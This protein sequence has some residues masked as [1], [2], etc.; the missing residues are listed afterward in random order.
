VTIELPKFKPIGIIH[1]PY[2]TR[3]DAPHQG[4]TKDE[5]SEIEV[6][7]EY[8]N[9]LTGIERFNKLFIIYCLHRSEQPPEDLMVRPFSSPHDNEKRD[10]PRGVFTTCAPVRPN[11]LALTLVELIERKGNILKVKGMDAIDG[12]PLLD[13]KPFIYENMD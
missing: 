13:I 4:F 8:E 5:I 2:K 3:E 7:Q 11:P 6:F 10:P 9:G 1:T 12:S